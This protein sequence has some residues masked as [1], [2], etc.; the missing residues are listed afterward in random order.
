MTTSTTTSTGASTSSQINTAGSSTY[1]TGTAS[2]LDTQALIDAAVAQY[3]QPADALDAKITAN[4]T[5][6]AAYQ[7]LQSLISALSTSMSKLAA[8]AFSTVASGATDFQAKSVGV[9]AS[10][11]STA[12]NYLT[13]SA[14]G[15]AVAASYT[16][17]VD[18][19]AASEAV[20]SNGFSRSD[21]LGYA[22]VFSLGEEGA[23]AAQITVTADMSLSDVAAAVNDVS[24]SSGV[25]ASLVKASDGGYRLVLTANDSNRAIAATTVSGDDVLA[26]LGVTDSSGGF[27]NELQ[28]A[29]PAL[30][31]IAGQQIASDTNEVSDAISGLTLSLTNATPAGVSLTLAVKPDTS[32]ATADIGDFVSAY[33]SLRAYVSANQQVGAGGAVDSS[34]APL[35]ADSLMTG[36]SQMLNMLLSTPSASATGGYG[37]LADLGF[38]FDSS[39]NL[40][41]S[42]SA[43]LDS[44]LSGGLAQV[45]SMFQSTF[46]PSN[47]ALKLLANASTGG[48]DFTLDVTVDANGDPTGASVGGDASAFTIQGARIVGASD[49]PYAGLS[50]AFH[51]SADASI[52]VSIKPG[53]ANQIVNFAAM[54]GGATGFIQQQIGALAAQDDSWAAQAS[55]IRSKASDYQTTLINKYARMEQEVSA[56][57][58]VQ[59]QIKAILDGQSSSS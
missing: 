6:I 26:G 25:S 56:A 11:A 58:L 47:D 43:A 15:D 19:L 17:S 18:Q 10:D 35:F 49:G 4:K 53:L 28:K 51:A 45:A 22:G 41:Q 59:A 57:Q 34:T 40:V 12:A 48:F 8:P 54:Y 16:L 46:T 44:A 31:T 42:D 38:A 32:A 37:A 52:Q 9:T 55:D 1:V 30:V 13:A 29:Q 21:A 39:N 2:G 5:K 24:A 23:S 7:Q 36:A 14:A 33:N 27:A 20:A 3:A 50:F